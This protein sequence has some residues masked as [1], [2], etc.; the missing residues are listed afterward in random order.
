MHEIWSSIKYS[1]VSSPLVIIY[2]S[3]YLSIYLFIYLYILY[4]YVIFFAFILTWNNFIFNSRNYLQTNSCAM[5]A[6]YAPSYANIL[7][8]HFERKLMY[9]FIKRFSLIYLRIFDNIFFLY[10][11]ALRRFKFSNGEIFK[12]TQHKI[13]IPDTWIPDIKNNYYIFR[14]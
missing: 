14:Y 13:R 10:R 9:T 4:I 8:D 2:L 5:A 1:V 12:W 7:L 11:L 6:I 3:I